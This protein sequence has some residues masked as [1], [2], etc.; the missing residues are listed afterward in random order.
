MEDGATW[1]WNPE[2]GGDLRV[3]GT[4]HP[5]G[6]PFGQRPGT[7]ISVSWSPDGRDI[8][9]T[10]E[11]HV[12]EIW[13]LSEPEPRHQLTTPPMANDEESPLPIKSFAWSSDGGCVRLL[14]ADASAEAIDAV[15]GERCEGEKTW[16]PA[17]NVSDSEV[18]L[19]TET[20]A[21]GRAVW[22]PDSTR[23]AI[24]QRNGVILWD[25]AT[26]TSTG[27]WPAP[28]GA[29]IRH[30]EWL[31][32]GLYRV[33]SP[34]DPKPEWK[35]AWDKL[36]SADAAET[37]EASAQVNVLEQFDELA[38][39][40]FAFS[41]EGRNL[42]SRARDY[43]SEAGALHVWNLRSNEGRTSLEAPGFVFG[44]AISWSRDGTL[45]A[46]AFAKDSTQ[47][48]D[49]SSW[50]V[51]SS[52]PGGAFAWAPAGKQIAAACPPDPENR[53]P[54]RFSPLC[55]YDAST[56]QTLGPRL[57]TNGASPQM[58]AW[59]PNG[60]LLATEWFD[61]LRI[62]EVETGKLLHK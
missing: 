20:S 30:I 5:P 12:L 43:G 61:E 45:L 39:E 2:N 15:K 35:L 51:I 62:W 3:M 29:Q 34:E 8:A 32:D 48:L 56:G 53:T 50:K 44:D 9:F 37:G 31:S 16:K 49:T 28:E 22:S 38:D 25:P 60:K 11:D 59:S 24:A 6:S 47:V 36:D 40:A 21:S 7:P 41:P 18:E 26:R 13:D 17:Q 33:L 14:F 23:L 46:V 19:P 55:I 42:A 4:W 57:I 58:G 54:E 52:L 27:V 10:S 1:V